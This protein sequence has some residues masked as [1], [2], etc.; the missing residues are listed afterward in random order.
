MTDQDKLRWLREEHRK[1]AIENRLAAARRHSYLG[2]AVLGG[3]DGCVTTFAVVSGAVGGGF[4]S[5]VVIVL[6]FANLVADGFSMAVSN[7]Q[8]TKSERDRVE[9]A[10]LDEQRHIEQV[11]E[12]ER[13]EI[14]QI[15]RAKGF[16]GDLLERIV[17]VITRD[18]TLWVDTMVREE[19]GLQVEGP[20]PYWAGITT[21][22]AFLAV[23]FIPL[24]PFLFAEVPLEQR[25]LW[26]AVLTA[27]AFFGIGLARGTVLNRSPILSGISTLLTGGAAASL[28]YFIGAWLRQ[29]FGAA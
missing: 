25:F 8:A 28:A 2:D 20:S 4:G 15:F 12:G 17:D 29:T 27:I 6:G 24:A 26:S 11:P 14:R 16:E 1:E 18:P 19:L 9:E 3:I 13:E 5:V 7:Y 23:G 10:R 22:A 21:F